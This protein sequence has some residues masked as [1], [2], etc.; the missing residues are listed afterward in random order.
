[1]ARVRYDYTGRKIKNMEELDKN[2]LK[3]QALRESFEKRVA[4]LV[5]DYEDRIA[6]L[7]VELTLMAHQMRELREALEGD[8]RDAKEDTELSHD[9]N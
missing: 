7:R 3:I 2:K 5:G 1:M 6:D 9:E 4:I 8:D